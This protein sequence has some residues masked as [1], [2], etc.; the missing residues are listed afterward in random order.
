M[1]FYWAYQKWFSWF[2]LMGVLCFPV[3]S[4]LM[5]L[6]AM[7][8]LKVKWKGPSWLP[9]G[10]QHRVALLEGGALPTPPNNCALRV[11]RPLTGESWLLRDGDLLPAEHCGQLLCR[12]EGSR[13]YDYL[14]LFWLR[15]PKKGNLRITV[16]P[17]PIPLP[18]LPQLD[19]YAAQAWRP[20]PGGGFSEQH[21]LRQYRPGDNLNQIHWKLTAKTG[22]YIVREAMEPEKN[23]V[24]V[25]LELRG[26]PEELDV[27]FGQL[28]WLSRHLLEM[29]LPHEI[30]AL[31]GQGVQSQAV[32]DEGSMYQVI[33]ALLG[34]TP[35]DDKAVLEPAA[36]GWQYRIGGGD[37]EA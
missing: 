7:V 12:M 2:I 29:G 6:P 32:T 28:L 5:S 34:C 30:R 26:N 36:A 37:H 17:E 25:E 3:A 27:R 31:T 10:A 20:K 4:L 33:D 11:E 35:A 16:R 24:L 9:R 8:N 1:V 23:R 21:E 13:V 18:V 19:G 14:G 15:V 22:E